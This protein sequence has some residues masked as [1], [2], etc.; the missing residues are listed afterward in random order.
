MVLRQLRWAH[1]LHSVPDLLKAGRLEMF[2]KSIE[3]F[4]ILTWEHFKEVSF[5]PNHYTFICFSLEQSLQVFVSVLIPCWYFC[6]QLCGLLYTSAYQ[7]TV[8]I[9]TSDCISRATTWDLPRSEAKSILITRWWLAAVLLMI[10]E[11]EGGQTKS[12]KYGI[13]SFLK[14]GS[15]SSSSYKHVDVC[16]KSLFLITWVLIIYLMLKIGDK[17]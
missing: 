10:A 17:T 2:F 3:L 5:V 1:A 7:V 14:I 16:L 15:V 9:L 12:L 8:L 6:T 13:T 4:P 11:G